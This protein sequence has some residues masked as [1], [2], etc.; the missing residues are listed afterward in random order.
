MRLRERF[1]RMMYGRY[2]SS[3]RN[4]DTG[5]EVPDLLLVLV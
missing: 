3:R 1:Q 4:S 5:C 2:G